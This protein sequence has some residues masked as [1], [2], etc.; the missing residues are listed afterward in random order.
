MMPVFGYMNPGAGSLLLQLILMG[1]AGL[2]VGFRSFCSTIRSF[3][4]GKK[5]G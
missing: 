4:G 1:T 2:V 5:K 3:F